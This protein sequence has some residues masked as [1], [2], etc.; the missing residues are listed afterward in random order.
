MGPPFSV[1]R[2]ISGGLIF[3]STEHDRHR[4]GICGLEDLHLNFILEEEEV[5]ARGGGEEMDQ[6]CNGGWLGGR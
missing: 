4:G 1:G 2:N 5:E 3:G 6:S